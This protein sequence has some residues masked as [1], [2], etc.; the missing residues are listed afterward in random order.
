M[1]SKSA[2]IIG[3]GHLMRWNYFGVFSFIF[4]ISSIEV[5][6]DGKN[7][8]E[9]VPQLVWIESYANHMLSIDRL[10]A[11]DCVVHITTDKSRVLRNRVAKIKPVCI[12]II[13]CYHS[14]G[15]CFGTWGLPC[16][17]LIIP[18]YSLKIL[19]IYLQESS[20]QCWVNWICF[21]WVDF[22]LR[23]ASSTIHISES[24]GKSIRKDELNPP[25]YFLSINSKTTFWGSKR[26]EK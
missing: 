10:I 23:D 25:V 3:L 26:E 12:V 4:N 17:P 19:M 5:G 1:I 11:A 9:M 18:S 14:F 13:K 15:M 2:L 6:F 21:L 7:S 20:C 24:I 22:K 8:I 16:W